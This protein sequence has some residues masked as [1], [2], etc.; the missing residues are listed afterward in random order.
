MENWAGSAS[1]SY[2]LVH[3]FGC[4]F[5]IKMFAFVVGVACGAKKFLYVTQKVTVACYFWLKCLRLSWVWPAALKSFC[6]LR[7]KWRFHVILS[8]GSPAGA[9][10]CSIFVQKQWKSLK[11]SKDTKNQSLF[12]GC[13]VAFGVRI[14]NRNR[15]IY[16]YIYIW[17]LRVDPKQCFI[18]L[19]VVP[20]LLCNLCTAIFAL[21]FLLWALQKQFR[22]RCMIY[23]HLLQ[24]QQSWISCFCIAFH[25]SEAT[26]ATSGL[27]DNQ[28]YSIEKVPKWPPK[29]TGWHSWRDTPDLF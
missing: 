11:M 6:I 10:S 23:V 22:N 19:F 8:L 14:Q 27:P 5:F 20:P 24:N 3:E 29:C 28:P 9:K 12:Y 21:Q 7:L 18:F 16:I 1:R 2:I 4:L 13:L 25:C 26:G 17:Y 15:H